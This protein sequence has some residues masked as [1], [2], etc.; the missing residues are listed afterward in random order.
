MHIPRQL[1]RSYEETLV[2]GEIFARRWTLKDDTLKTGR[3]SRKITKKLE[4]TI[5]K[6]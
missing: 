4:W 1:I 2:K 3:S 5:G 6:G